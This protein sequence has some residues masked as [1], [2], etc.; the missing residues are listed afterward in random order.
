MADLYRPFHTCSLKLQVHRKLLD[1]SAGRFLTARRCPLSVVIDGPLEPLVEAHLRFVPEQLRGLADVRA[2]PFGVVDRP[3]DVDQVA[4][5]SRGVEDVLGE[6]A[7]RDL[8]RLP[9]G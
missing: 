5:G 7:N 8:V 4:L 2:P 3:L 1:E 9:P 6:F